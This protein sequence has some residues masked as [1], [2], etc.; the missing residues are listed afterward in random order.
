MIIFQ[1]QNQIGFIAQDVQKVI[2]E[3]VSSI[4]T[5]K[6][7]DMLGL[8]T[9][10]IIPYLVNSVKELSTRYNSLSDL[11]DASASEKKLST[12]KRVLSLE[13]EKHK[14]PRGDNNVTPIRRDARPVRLYD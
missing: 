5:K 4:P 2:P 10:F 8:K 13:K 1:G 14:T 3:A 9:E 6:N 12:D 7:Q 11:H